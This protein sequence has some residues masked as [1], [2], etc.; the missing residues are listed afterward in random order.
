M[1]NSLKEAFKKILISGKGGNIEVL[2]TK[3]N[4]TWRSF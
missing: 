2:N 1:E 3:N 4:R